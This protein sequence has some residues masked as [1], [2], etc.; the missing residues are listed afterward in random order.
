MT[1]K[2]TENSVELFLFSQIN[3]KSLI[4]NNANSFNFF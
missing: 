2:T 1:F 3:S 4:P